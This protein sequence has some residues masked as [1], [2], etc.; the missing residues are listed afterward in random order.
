MHVAAA[1]EIT[2]AT[3]LAIHIWTTSHFPLYFTEASDFI[4]AQSVPFVL[5]HFLWCTFPLWD[6][7]DETSYLFHPHYNQ[8]KLASESLSKDLNGSCNCFLY[9]AIF[10]IF[11]TSKNPRVFVFR[12]K[13]GHTGFLKWWTASQL[14]CF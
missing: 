4:W 8:I 9:F 3:T 13:M 12:G 5:L 2:K 6:W 7:S 14:L 1:S 11:K 10:L